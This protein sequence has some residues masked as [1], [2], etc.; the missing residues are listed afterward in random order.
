MTQKVTKS[1]PSD[2][3]LSRDEIAIMV[4][5]LTLTLIC[6]RIYLV[7][8]HLDPCSGSDRAPSTQP[9]CKTLV[10]NY[11]N[12]RLVYDN[13]NEYSTALSYYKKALEAFTRKSQVVQLWLRVITTLARFMI[14]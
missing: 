7:S 6:T 10:S 12:I 9:S 8:L 3:S 5:R 1:K 4:A 14:V 2:D 11:N 13:N